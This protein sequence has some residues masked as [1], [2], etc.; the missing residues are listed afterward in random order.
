M[1]HS[2]TERV[3][4]YCHVYINAVEAYVLH[5]Q[6]F[7]C[8]VSFTPYCTTNKMRIHLYMYITA[9]S[10]SYFGVFYVIFRSQTLR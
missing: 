5:M 8:Q 7:Y 9:V 6:Y 2:F 3:K 1:K 10:V 4:Q